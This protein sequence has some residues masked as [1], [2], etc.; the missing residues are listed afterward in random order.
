MKREWSKPVLQELSVNKTF[1]NPNSG[2]HLD[3][4]YEEGTPREAL[5][6]S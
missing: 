3:Y 5:T 6:W 1:L 2:D 4:D